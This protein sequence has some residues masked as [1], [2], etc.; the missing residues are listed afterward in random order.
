MSCLTFDLLSVGAA[1]SEVFT[2]TNVWL[3]S[4]TDQWNVRRFSSSP[5]K[6]D[7]LVFS[8]ML[9]LTLSFMSFQPKTKLLQQEIFSYFGV[10]QQSLLHFGSRAETSPL[11]LQLTSDK[12]LRIFSGFYCSRGPEAA[13]WNVYGRDALKISLKSSSVRAARLTEYIHEA[14]CAPPTPEGHRLW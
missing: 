10:Q 1:F 14:T 3:R 9:T 8:E 2:A 12:Q 13:L 7:I 11:L 6:L 5:R 4:E